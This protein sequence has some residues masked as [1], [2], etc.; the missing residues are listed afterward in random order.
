MLF[1]GKKCNI[2][3]SISSSL[4]RPSSFPKTFFGKIRLLT[5]FLIKN[6]FL[7]FPKRRQFHLGPNLYHIL[8]CIL[9]NNLMLGKMYCLKKKFDLI[10]N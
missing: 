1:D 3:T 10:K 8:P 7:N 4:L 9:E 6:S 2:L 5:L